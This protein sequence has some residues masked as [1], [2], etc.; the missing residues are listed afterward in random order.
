MAYQRRSADS[1]RRIWPFGL[2]IGRS[3]ETA[4]TD[5]QNGVERQ[6]VPQ[7]SRRKLH[8]DTEGRRRLPR[9]CDN[10][11][12]VASR[13]SK[14]IDDVCNTR[15]RHSAQGCRPPGEFEAQRAQQ[16]AQR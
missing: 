13:L 9:G 4:T 8:E 6:P 16:A 11:G 2:A 3:D 12:N 5:S 7:R 10:Y 1:Q 14:F 15:R